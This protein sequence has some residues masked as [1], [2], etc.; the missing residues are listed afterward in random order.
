MG[1]NVI[2]RRYLDG[3][4]QDRFCGSMKKKMITAILCGTVSVF[5]Y[6]YCRRTIGGS[7]HLSYRRNLDSWSGSVNMSV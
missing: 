4:S 7:S 1:E 5:T 6:V 2:S 3:D